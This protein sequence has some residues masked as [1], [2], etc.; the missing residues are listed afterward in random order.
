LTQHAPIYQHSKRPEWGY[1]AVVEVL[2]DRTLFK[3]DDGLSR[4][5]SHDHIKLMQRVDLEEAEATAIHARIAKHSARTAKVADKAKAKR[6]A[7][8]TAAAPID[9]G[10]DLAADDS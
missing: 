9:V 4:T 1:C 10:A 3:F 6:A 8:K 5:I 7:A 2:E